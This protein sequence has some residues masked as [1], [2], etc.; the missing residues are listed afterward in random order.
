MNVLDRL[1]DDLTVIDFDTADAMAAGALR[2]ELEKPGQTIGPADI[3]IAGQA[4][5]RGWT[6]VTNDID[7]F[8]RVQNLPLIDWRVSDRP[9]DVR[10]ILT[11]LARFPKD[12]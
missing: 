12:K 5:N 4:L 7:H 8:G 9:L 2:H 6:I 10:E 1:L 11:R 3:L